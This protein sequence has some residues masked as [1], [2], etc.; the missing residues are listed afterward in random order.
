MNPET[1]KNN[2]EHF[3][4]FETIGAGDVLSMYLHGPAYHVAKKDLT[5]QERDIL[6]KILEYFQELARDILIRYPDYDSYKDAA[7]SRASQKHAIKYT[8]TVPI[9][10]A[11]KHVGIM[12]KAFQA[13]LEESLP[14]DG[15]EL[16]VLTCLTIPQLKELI[17]KLNSWNEGDE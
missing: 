3:S 11:K 13:T 4:I 10:I 1:M 9:K 15:Y 16:K 7:C 17:S 5:Q 6:E 8:E 2:P 12:R 14:D